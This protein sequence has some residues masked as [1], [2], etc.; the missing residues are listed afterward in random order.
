[1]STNDT[2]NEG[3]YGLVYINAGKH[4]GK[5]GLYDDDDESGKVIV[6]VDRPF[7]DSYTVIRLSSLIPYDEKNHGPLIS[8]GLQLFINPPKNVSHL[9]QK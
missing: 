6:Y 1:M 7:I 5:V 8:T 3:D 2:V 4:K 9:I